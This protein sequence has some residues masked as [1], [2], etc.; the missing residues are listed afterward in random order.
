MKPILINLN[1]MSDSREVYDSQPNI[2]LTIFI[3][4][5][6]GLVITALLW[7]YFGRIDIV[8]KSDGILRPNDQIATV[9]NTYSG[10]LEQVNVKDGSK[11]KKGDTLYVINHD[12]L[13]SELLYYQEQ[14]EDVDNTLSLLTK[15]KQSVE[16]GKNYFNQSDKE[17]EYYLKYQSFK[18][19]YDKLKNNGNISKKQLE[20]LQKRLANTKKLIQA[21]KLNENLFANSG[22]EKEFYNLYLK[23]QSD[24]Q[25]LVIQY[26]K[27]KEEIDHSTTHEDLVNSLEYYKNML[28]GLKKLQ[29][30]IDN[31]ENNFDEISSYSL[32]YEEYVNKVA[33]LNADYKQA[34]ENYEINK[35]LQGLAVT[36]LEVQQSKNAMDQAKRA[37]KTYK[38][39]YLSNVS[40]NVTEA[41]NKLK[42][43]NISKQKTSS[44]EELYQENKK[45]KNAALDNF[46]LKYL[47]ELD[48]SVNSLKENITSQKSNSGSF[49]LQ[50][51]QN[52]QNEDNNLQVSL[53][54]YKGN[55]LQSVIT[56]INTYTDKKEELQANINKLKVQLSNSIVKA[57]KSGVVNSNVE[58]VVGDELSSSTEV[59]TIIPENNSKYKANIYVNNKDIGKLREGMNIKFNIYALPQSEYGYLKGKI[60]SISKDYKVDS[61]SNS[62]YYLVEAK[63][64]NKILYNSQGNKGVL[65][66]GMTCQAQMI[67]EKKRILTYVLEKINLWVNN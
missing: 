62:G 39:N 8:V 67:T 6:L 66:V 1:D 24:Y 54:Q 63:L 49:K 11:V 55:E 16:N 18:F 51:E 50:D 22:N 36:E 32:Q 43:L 59:M 61:S 26:D 28:G 47:T 29:K 46:K 35:E 34:K 7:M 33:D 44:K 48:N 42:E 25:S 57:S 15:Y 60:T 21:I 45:E 12:D 64:D 4:V 31:S 58:L 9:M 65:K 27:A 37:I 14:I 17:E 23:Y 3:Y 30:S 38:T 53:K 20:L 41:D 40:S 10:T 56:D 52:L 2:V 13:S 5:I 19:N